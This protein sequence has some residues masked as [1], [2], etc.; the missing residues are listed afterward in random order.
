MPAVATSTSLGATRHT[1]EETLFDSYTCGRLHNIGDHTWPT[2]QKEEIQGN[3]MEGRHGSSTRKE[4]VTSMHV[5]LASGLS[6][7]QRKQKQERSL[8]L[9]AIALR[10]RL[11]REELRLQLEQR[12]AEE[13]RGG[14]TIPNVLREALFSL[15][16][17]TL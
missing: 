15:R 11:A 13:N 4:S 2:L 12:L 14:P 1:K 8:L 7:R 16:N 10:Q 17:A 6:R 5:V 3:N 9:E